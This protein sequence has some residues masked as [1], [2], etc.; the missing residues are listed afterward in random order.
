MNFKPEGK[1]W[2]QIQL[3]SWSKRFRPKTSSI[4]QLP[5]ERPQSTELILKFTPSKQELKKVNIDS[6]MAIKPKTDG[7]NDIVGS[8]TDIR[9]IL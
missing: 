2:E 3:G 7:F 9:N 5:E 1:Q 6:A 8:M 4:K